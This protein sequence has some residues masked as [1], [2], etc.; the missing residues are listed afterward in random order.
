MSDRL[1]T[2]GALAF[3][4]LFTALAARSGD[5]AWMT[6]PFLTYLLAGLL[7]APCAEDVRLSAR[8]SLRTSRA[9]GGAVEV[10]VEVRNEGARTVH[11][12]L[13]DALGPGVRMREGAPFR[14]ATLRPGEATELAYS[15]PAARGRFAWTTVRAVASDP[16]ELFETAQ[17]VPAQGAIDVFP[18]L[19]RLG[20]LPLHPQDTLPT[21]GPIPAHRGGSGIEL[22]GVREYQV[23]DSLRSVDWRHTAR[24]PRQLFTRELEQ[25][26]LANVGLLLDAR[27]AAGSGAGGGDLFEHSVR[28]TASLAEAFLRQGHRVSLLVFA[29][30]VSRVFPDVG[31]LQL[32]RILACLAAATAGAERYGPPL[33]AASL[34]LFPSR[35][36]VIVVSPLT[37]DDASHFPLLRAQGHQVVLVSPDPVD[38]P[39]RVPAPDPLGELALRAARIERH[40]DLRAVARLRIPV[41]D[42]RVSEPLHPL[43]REALRP[44]RGRPGARGGGA[45]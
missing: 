23:G 17:A 15:F 32:R 13:R 24:H 38:F 10:T 6:L 9:G 28:A 40:L 42:W 12:R 36:I 43:V 20:T 41:V 14:R 30:S 27:G 29:E 39:A 35:S 1:L 4:L 31:R 11:L 16:L 45:A 3:G 7:G 34:R 21:P 8:R 25:E 22:W 33:G 5:L 18:D 2:V 44:G 37:A 19:V 26:Q